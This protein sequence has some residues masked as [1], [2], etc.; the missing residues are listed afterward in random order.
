MTGQLKINS[1]IDELATTANPFS[2]TILSP[3]QCK[4]HTAFMFTSYV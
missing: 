1:N 2:Q 3:A 4:I